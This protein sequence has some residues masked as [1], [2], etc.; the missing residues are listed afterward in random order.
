MLWA[1][2]ASATLK[3]Q[4]MHN[5][6]RFIGLHLNLRGGL[7]LRLN[8]RKLAAARSLSVRGARSR[9]AGGA[10]PVAGSSAPLQLWLICSEIHHAEVRRERVLSPPPSRF[11]L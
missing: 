5:Q 11:S 4:K 8:S 3:K 7:R 1:V 10:H 2:T 9:R 6:C